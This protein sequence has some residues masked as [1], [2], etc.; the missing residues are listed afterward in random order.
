MNGDRIVYPV[1]ALR[2]DFLV[3]HAG[4]GHAEVSSLE[5]TEVGFCMLGWRDGPRA[6]MAALVESCLDQPE[7]SDAAA[8]QQPSSTQHALR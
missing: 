5:L 8:S 7:T 1:P 2:I 6:V 3:R 4:E